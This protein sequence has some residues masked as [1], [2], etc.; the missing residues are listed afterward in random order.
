MRC[1]RH[2]GGRWGTPPRGPLPSTPL[3]NDALRTPPP[4]ASNVI[5]EKNVGGRDR[6]VRGVL[7]T[8]LLAVA[9]VAYR[10]ENA[11]AAAVAALASGG[12]LF[13]AVTQFCGCNAALGVDTTSDD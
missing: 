9:L 2:H 12:L 7:G 5:P 8:V 10:R 3:A 13:N 6:L 4:R 1:W 11:P